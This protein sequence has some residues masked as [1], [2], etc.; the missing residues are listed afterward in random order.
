MIQALGLFLHLSS[1]PF[2]IFPH[3]TPC[4]GRTSSIILVHEG[5]I[6]CGA[7]PVKHHRIQLLKVSLLLFC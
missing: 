6:G 3:P 1:L 4:T 7:L 5:H 2:H